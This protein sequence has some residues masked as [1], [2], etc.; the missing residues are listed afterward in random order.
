[1]SVDLL[2]NP[3]PVKVR[4][5][6]KLTDIQK[7]LTRHV[8][9]MD[10]CR[11]PKMWAVETVFAKRLIAKYGVEFLLWVPLIEGHKVNSLLFYSTGL[12]YHYLSD[13]MVDFKKFAN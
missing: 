12:G 10:S 3:Q 13:Q 11:D 8:I 5:P 1:M 2:Q 4:K 7:I 6:R 9:G